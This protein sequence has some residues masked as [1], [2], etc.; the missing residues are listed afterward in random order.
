M[1]ILL[2]TSNTLPKNLKTKKKLP[3][4][5]A[6]INIH[7]FNLVLQNN[8]KNYSNIKNYKVEKHSDTIKQNDNFYILINDYDIIFKISNKKKN[9]LF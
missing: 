9:Q 4:D 3:F 2:D 7:Q 1:I 8:F 6:E 5:N